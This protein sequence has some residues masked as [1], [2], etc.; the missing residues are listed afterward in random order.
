MQGTGSSSDVKRNIP[1]NVV[2]KASS[3]Q[4]MFHTSE[5]FNN[6]QLAA[7]LYALGLV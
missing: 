2:Y 3:S 1:G 7:T 5:R 6:E 4:M